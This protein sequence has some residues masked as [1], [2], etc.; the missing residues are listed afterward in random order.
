M[1]TNVARFES[2]GFVSVPNVQTAISRRRRSK[3]S[4]ESLESSTTTPEQ[5]TTPSPTTSQRRRRGKRIQSTQP[6]QSTS[7]SPDHEPVNTARSSIWELQRS[8]R[9]QKLSDSTTSAGKLKKG[10]YRPRRIPIPYNIE[11]FPTLEEGN[12]YKVEKSRNYQATSTTTMRRSNTSTGYKL[13]RTQ[14]PYDAPS[15]YGNQTQSGSRS[16]TQFR[17]RLGF[18]SENQSNFRSNNQSQ[19]RLN[20]Q[21]QSDSNRRYRPNR[22]LILD[23]DDFDR[24]DFRDRDRRRMRGSNANYNNNEPRIGQWINGRKVRAEPLIFENTMRRS[25]RR[26]QNPIRSIRGKREAPKKSLTKKKVSQNR[27]MLRPS[28]QRKKNENEKV[29][30]PRIQPKKSPVRPRRKRQIQNDEYMEERHEELRPRK[31]SKKN[32]S[33]NEE[34]NNLRPRRQQSKH[35]NFEDL[36]ETKFERPSPRMKVME[37][38]VFPIENKTVPIITKPK[39]EKKKIRKRPIPPQIK[40]S[41]QEYKNI[42]DSFLIKKK[43]GL[44][45]HDVKS[46]KNKLTK[47]IARKDFVETVYS[48]NEMLDF[49][50]NKDFYSMNVP[51][52]GAAE[53]ERMKKQ[54]QTMITSPNANNYLQ[55]RTTNQHSKQQQMISSSMVTSSANQRMI[56][57]VS[58]NQTSTQSM[59]TSQFIAQK[60]STPTSV[61]NEMSHFVDNQDFS[62]M[63][64]RSPSKVPNYFQNKTSVQPRREIFIEQYLGQKMSLLSTSNHRYHGVLYTVDRSEKAIALKE[65]TCNGIKYEFVV[66][67]D[68]IIRKLWLNPLGNPNLYNTN[69]YIEGV[70]FGC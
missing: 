58:T 44:S 33:K 17:D 32:Y 19:S 24:I 40:L 5:S 42:R 70:F 53:H 30:L 67:R 55:Q 60:S 37:T 38:D 45:L 34:M 29:K 4:L 12:K 69:K 28:S 56:T 15:N 59:I 9:R 6:Q 54:S 48:K 64:R 13:R 22:S 57:S 61:E 50:D 63:H 41:E 14:I 3:K 27:I 62:N 49:V 10:V 46:I 25:V 18:K 20:F 66:F 11:A 68:A 43:N 65:V 8:V 1:S 35:V 26:T 47:K 7:P 16:N 51:I 36:E 31:L 52:N 39:I 2:G 21:S 23:R